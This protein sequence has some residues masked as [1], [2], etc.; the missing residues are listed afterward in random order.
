MA[1][2]LAIGIDIDSDTGNA[3]FRWGEPGEFAT[4]TWGA[5]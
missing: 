5:C 3:C 4:Q 2:K 1:E